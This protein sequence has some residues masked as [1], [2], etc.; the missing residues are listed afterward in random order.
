MLICII[1]GIARSVLKLFHSVMIL[2]TCPAG[3]AD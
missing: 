2:Q 1:L 3:T